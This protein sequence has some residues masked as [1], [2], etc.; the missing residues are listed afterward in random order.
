[1][2]ALLITTSTLPSVIMTRFYRTVVHFTLHPYDDF[3][4]RLLL[5]AMKQVKC[6]S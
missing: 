6:E 3:H 1:M 5:V 4:A 2:A